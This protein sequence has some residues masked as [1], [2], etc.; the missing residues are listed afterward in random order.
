MT[1]ILTITLSKCSWEC[2]LSPFVTRTGKELVALTDSRNR[3][4]ISVLIKLWVELL[5]IRVIMGLAP[6]VAL[7]R[8]ILGVVKPDRAWRVIYDH[9]GRLGLFLLW[10][11]SFL[12]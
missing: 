5:S 6:I 1:L 12:H 10:H 3:V 9:V 8:I 7:T 2:N 4:A 11:P